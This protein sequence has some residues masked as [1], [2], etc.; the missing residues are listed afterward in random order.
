[1][2]LRGYF[3]FLEA[4]RARLIG[5]SKK[6]CG[7]YTLADLQQ[8]A[9]VAAVEVSQERGREIDFGVPSD[10][11]AVLSRLYLDV[12]RRADKRVRFAVRIDQADEDGQSLA[13]RVK[14]ELA[15][16]TKPVG[17][18]ADPDEEDAKWAEAVRGS[19][20]E[21]AAYVILLQR[22]EWNRR[23]LAEHLR[24][25]V[26]TLRDRVERAA[27]WAVVQP[28]LFDGIELIDEEFVAARAR[29]RYGPRDGC[30]CNSQAER[31]FCQGR[32]T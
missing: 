16:K 17:D 18:D 14:R 25:T 15:A 13:A 7:E 20:S 2:M 1:M 5:I 30:H 23:A 22:F 24:I 21:A 6:A 4:N 28:G 10:G 12:V 32:M 29:E 19:Y 8:A 3:E 9:W 11:E 27:A 31:H 26:A